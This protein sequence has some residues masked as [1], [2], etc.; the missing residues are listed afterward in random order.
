MTLVEC[1][2]VHVR[3]TPRTIFLNEHAITDSR[4]GATIFLHTVK[5]VHKEKISKN[6]GELRQLAKSRDVAGFASYV[7]KLLQEDFIGWLRLLKE[8]KLITLFRSTSQISELR[9]LLGSESLPTVP[10]PD[11]E[12]LWHHLDVCEFMQYVFA[13]IDA[14]VLALPCRAADPENF[15]RTVVRMIEIANYAFQK[16]V[17][18]RN[19]SLPQRITE[20]EKCTSPCS[21]CEQR[22]TVTS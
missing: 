14:D 9:T 7:T 20:T 1:P 22:A 5:T 8:Q 10:G 11:L 13:K 3:Q 18:S 15:A 21:G 4:K 17:A 6:I 2:R 12:K 19:T 16:N